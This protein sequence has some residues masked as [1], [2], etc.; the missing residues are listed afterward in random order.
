MTNEEKTIR[1]IRGGEIFGHLSKHSDITAY[2]IA[3]NLAIL[4]DTLISIKDIL[5][6]NNSKEKEKGHWIYSGYDEVIGEYMY[7]CSC[8]G[9]I[10]DGMYHFCKDCGA[11][12]SE[13]S[14]V[15]QDD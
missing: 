3:I 13:E 8:C 10:S 4:N 12:M 1:F 11:E 15:E 9:G 6:S 2:Q 5:T 7:D 14:E